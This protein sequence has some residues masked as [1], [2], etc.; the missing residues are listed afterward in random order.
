MLL[1]IAS[2]LA[3]TVSTSILHPMAGTAGESLV[4]SE[5]VTTVQ[6]YYDA[7][8]VMIA[9]GEPETLR[10]IAH[11]DF[12]DIDDLET[13]PGGLT[14]LEGQARWLR[15]AAPGATLHPTIA[16]HGPHDVV[17][18]VRIN[19][20]APVSAMGLTP[21]DTESLWPAYEHLRVVDQ[22]VV[23]RQYSSGGI[24]QIEP[25][26]ELPFEMAVAEKRA[27]EVMVSTFQMHA[28]KTIWADGG[29]AM[30]RLISG[31]MQISV[32]IAAENAAMIRRPGNRALPAIEL[33]RAPETREIGP[34][35]VL[36]VPQGS[37]LTVTNHEKMAASLLSVRVVVPYEGLFDPQSEAADAV[38]GVTIT[39]W[40]YFR[41][42]RQ[43]G[44]DPTAIRVGSL[45]I[46]PGER[47]L[48][49]PKVQILII[50]PD[51]AQLRALDVASEAGGGSLQASPT[52][53][54]DEAF[55]LAW[56]S[57]EEAGPVAANKGWVRGQDGAMLINVGST[58]V[59]AWVVSIGSI[60]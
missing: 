33:I 51:G 26:A 19:L 27:V 17:A 38:P 58:P 16:G 1:G 60:E 6:R 53:T 34:G 41:D 2:I 21:V 50:H 23:E 48:V 11:P 43:D 31:R 9:T 5:N 30:V 40:L 45:S 59:S 37:R 36:I 35:D 25:V 12:Q 46:A 55:H 3:A 14:V 24:T 56:I 10:A 52:G 29:P 22:R 54:S 47:L 49:D 15:A 39:S 42:I 44:I 4:V 20:P 28:V 7:I 13:E 57:E 32:D 8:N 18:Q